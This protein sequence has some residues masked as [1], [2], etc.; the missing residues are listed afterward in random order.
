MIHN[1]VGKVR[2]YLLRG[3]VDVMSISL[4]Q[5]YVMHTSRCQLRNVICPPS[6]W[7]MIRGGF[8]AKMV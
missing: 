8:K 6:L 3:Q 7:H 5:M 4:L 1:R 2:S